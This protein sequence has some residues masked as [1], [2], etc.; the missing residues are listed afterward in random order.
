[1]VAAQVTP[2]TVNLN[3]VS[4]GSLQSKL[5][6][7]LGSNYTVGYNTST[8][9]LNISISGTG[10][11]AGV[12]TIAFSGSPTQTTPV[13]GGTNVTKNVDLDGVSTSNLLTTLQNDLGAGYNVTYNTNS[14]ALNISAVAGGTTLS[15]NSGNAQETGPGT[16]EVDTPTNITL[17]GQT[18]NSLASYLSSQLPGWNYSVTQDSNGVTVSPQWWDQEIYGIQSVSAS[19][20]QAYE[21]TPAVQ[22]TTT[23]TYINLTGVATSDL[24]QTIQSA[25][26]SNYG[27][28][29]DNVGSG[30]LEIYLNDW[31]NPS[32]PSSFTSSS[33]LQQ[34]TGSV[35]PVNTPSTI[36]L[37]G[38]STTNLA[39]SIVSQLGSAA[40]NYD[41][42]YD[43][44]SGAL[45]IALSAAGAASGITSITSNASGFIET[46]PAGTTGLSAVNIFTSDATVNGSTSLDVT[47]GSLTTANLGTSNGSTGANLSGSD[48][49][50]Q[51]GATASL[52][53][54]NSAITDISSQRGAVGANINRLAATAS[55]I[56]TEQLNLTSATNSILNADIGKTV[57]N[58]TQYN[59]LQST[60][61]ASLQQ[62][63]QAQQAVLKLL[64]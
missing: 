6:T 9:A 14:G 52:T 23:P 25:L 59:I 2:V 55:D 1:V 62:A 63:N 21:T 38:V 11:T 26:G 27:V 46:A 12:K 51:S 34:N 29:Y 53:M 30:F 28:N 58:M 61:M 20:V 24:Q 45:N 36:D 37:T 40:G 50:S 44:T 43:T 10:T 35:A 31:G 4:T 41:V 54:I 18:G 5:S 15:A 19:N 48:L 56:G 64:Q 49:L 60:G 57:A 22:P 3:G 47:V 33:T 39:S 42:T 17:D 7:A 16:P 32:G 8:G 13:V